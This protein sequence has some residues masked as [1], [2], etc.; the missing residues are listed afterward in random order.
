L[1]QDPLIQ[2]FSSQMRSTFSW[3]EWL[4]VVVLGL[5]VFNAIEIAYRELRRSM[6]IKFL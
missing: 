5:E 1:S 2:V 3:L 6:V 4:I